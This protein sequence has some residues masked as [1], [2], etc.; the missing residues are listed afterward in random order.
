MVI[1]ELEA[2]MGALLLSLPHGFYILLSP[3]VREM[4]KGGG[5][6]W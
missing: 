5:L 4:D 6:L 1:M 2:V 3:V